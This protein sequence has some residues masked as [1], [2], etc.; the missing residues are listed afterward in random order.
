MGMNEHS[1]VWS[2]HT[3]ILSF[4]LCH[5]TQV[6][7]SSPFFFLLSVRL[8]A[9]NF[10]NH[11]LTY[12]LLLP[13]L[14]TLLLRDTVREVLRDSEIHLAQEKMTRL[15]RVTGK[16]KKQ[17]EVPLQMFIWIFITAELRCKKA[18]RYSPVCVCVCK[19]ASCFVPLHSPISTGATP[20][21][22]ESW[23]LSLRASDVWV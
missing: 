20:P 14:T 4:N 3:F 9:C 2:T 8:S 6:Y 15:E 23:P 11:T 12:H 1:T 18:L 10:S 5:L 13:Q 7:Q 21:P 16:G 22:G 17:D 19:Q